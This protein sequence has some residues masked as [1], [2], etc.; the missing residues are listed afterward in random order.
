MAKPAI[1]TPPGDA[2]R[3]HLIPVNKIPA[4]T[5]R[6]MATHVIEAIAK[7]RVGEYEQNG[8]VVD[9]E[10][11]TRTRMRKEKLHNVAFEDRVWAA[12]ARLQFT[13][14]NQDRAFRLRY[15]I[16]TGQ[17]QKV[18]IFAA[19]D[20]VVLVVKCKSTEQIRAEQFKKES[21]AIASHKA[22][23]IKRIREE[24][25][26]H[27]VKFIL[28]SNN[29]TLSK[30]TKDRLAAEDIFH[31]SEDTVDYFLTLAD[32][33][34]AAA[35]YQLLGALFAEQKI[36]NLEPTV[37]AIRGSMGSYSYY[38]FSIEPARLLKMAY[39][40]HRNQANSDLMPTYQRLIKKSRLKNVARFV[41]GGGFFPNSIVL[42][43]ETKKKKGDLQ[44]DLATKTPGAVKAGL[45]HLPQTYRA[46]YVIDG[47]HRLYGY[48][49]SDRAETDLIPVVAFVDLD[50]AEQVKLFMQINENQQAVPKNLRNT[51]NSDL[52]WSSDNY[53]ERARAL[54]LRI[55]QHLGEQK[56]SPLYDRV[57]I[58]ENQ[59]THLRCITIEAISNGLARGN[60]IGAFT[61][62]G[63]KTHGSFY[64]GDNQ[65]T[66]DRLIPFL[67]EAFLYLSEGLPTQWA[68]GSS[69][70]GFVFMNN[71]VEAYLRLLSDIVDHVTE[72]DDI[73]PLSS[74]TEEIAGACEYFIDPLIEHLESLT[75]DEGEEYRK[76]YG[77]GA[78]LRYYHRLQQAVR[79]ARSDFNPAGLD[80][81]LKSQDK[82]SNNQA[83]EIVSDIEGLFKTDIR[84]RLEDEHGSEWERRGVPAKLRKELHIRAVDKNLD[85][86][87]SEEVDPWDMMY[88]V[89]Y[90][91]ILTQNHD[92]WKRRFEKWYTKPGEE[93]KAGGWKGRSS[94][95]L[96]LNEIRNDVSHSRGINEEA[97]ALLVELRSWLLEEEIDNEL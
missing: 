83:R 65:P 49:N 71:G 38:S 26:R 40:L 34:G 10:L 88:L 78:G 75:S 48:A 60:F 29:F 73:D 4:E 45:L 76:L 37:P 53:A 62:T 51:L 19:D 74:S 17:A 20:E 22:G 54:R 41:E 47:Q 5:R 94:W 58:G 27:K 89:D 36:P 46:A 3:D 66:A 96:E 25:P 13:H 68:L 35:K 1:T 57:I 8:W 14:L 52:L 67:E 85:L 33:L 12:F 92:L 63:A 24:Y 50:R 59:R 81:W 7:G 56:S 21:E 90:R 80:E 61:K 77:A 39:V 86:P 18:D 15:G 2:I 79:D 84:E 6:R 64:A 55:A 31:V 28:A 32:H 69:E 23:A 72:H 91:D 9:K 42:N 44:F 95:I 82:Q 43:I 16:A 11:K 87:S 70:G 30:E 97:F 93:E